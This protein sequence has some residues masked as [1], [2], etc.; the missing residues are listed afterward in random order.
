D[1]MDG[2]VIG[3]VAISAVTLGAIAWDLD[4]PFAVVL[5]AVL[6]ASCLGFLPFNFSPAT[7]FMGDAGSMLLGFMLASITL[8]SSS[9]APAFLALIIPMLAVGVPLFETCFAFI[10]RMLQGQHPFRAD[11]RHLHHRFQALGFSEKRT[12]LTFYYL[13]AY[14]GITAYVIQR[15]EARATLPLVAIVIIG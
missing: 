5:C 10:R 11:R 7:I 3:I 8:L 1:G 14:F 2:L 4:T 12:V 6:L 13:T 9:K 15:L